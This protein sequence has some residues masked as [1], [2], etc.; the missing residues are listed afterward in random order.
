[1]YGIR[2]RGKRE[3]TAPGMETAEGRAGLGVA[4]GETTSVPE[5]IRQEVQPQQLPR[6]PG[7]NNG[8]DGLNAALGRGGW[9]DLGLGLGLGLLG[10]KIFCWAVYL[11]WPELEVQYVSFGIE[12]GFEF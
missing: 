8:G 6:L 12:L 10:L 3:A 11:G 9:V 7:F 2:R 5:A 1:M 4:A